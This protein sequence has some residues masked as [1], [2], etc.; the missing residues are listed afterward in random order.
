MN[1]LSSSNACVLDNVDSENTY[2]QSKNEQTSLF[3][4]LEDLS[5]EEQRL[6]S[7]QIQLKAENLFLLYLIG[8]N[9][10][11]IISSIQIGLS[12]LEKTVP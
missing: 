12:T 5:Y 7:Q 3:A 11:K 4:K 10:W 2:Q 6:R 8:E 1:K 9:P